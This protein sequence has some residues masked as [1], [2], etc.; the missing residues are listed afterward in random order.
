VA[1]LENSL[2]VIQGRLIKKYLGRYQA[3]PKKY[4]KDEF[5]IAKELG[6][7]CI[8]FI[9]DYNDY[10]ENPLLTQNGIDQ[11]KAISDET[12]VKVKTIC[13][14]Y[15]MNA[16]LH[17]IDSK[18]VNQSQKIL[19]MLINNAA[20]IGVTDVVIPCVDNSSIDENS[21]NFF[22]EQLSKVLEVSEDKKINLALETDL[23]PKSFLSLLNL[24]DSKRV[25][26][27]YDIGNSA[28]LGFNP[29]EELNCYGDRITDIHIKD[30]ALNGGPV[31]LGQGNAEFKVFFDK[32]KEFN[33]CGPF[34]MQAYRDDEGLKVFKKQLQWIKPFL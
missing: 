13:A 20:K 19:V 18:V 31:E 34:I 21:S 17:S 1:T 5:Y 28:S 14:D 15:F 26:V 7:D 11:I 23:P 30:R 32:L 3:H 22:V 29:I 33:Y 16:P 10:D 27:N 8:E 4:W 24:F 25:T 9:L 12:G 6:L 2:G